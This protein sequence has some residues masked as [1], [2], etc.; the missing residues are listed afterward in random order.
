VIDDVVVKPVRSGHAE[1][2]QTP[3]TPPRG[4]GKGKPGAGFRDANP[5]YPSFAHKK[6]DRGQARDRGTLP[7]FLFPK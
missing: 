7:E 2:Q 5:A 3:P 6:P 1:G 4:S